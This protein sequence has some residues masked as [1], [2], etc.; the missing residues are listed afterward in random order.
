MK[1]LFIYFTIIVFTLFSCKKQERAP[2]GPTDI[3]IQ[4]LSDFQ[5]NEIT[6]N[7]YD[8][9]FIYGTLNAGATTD[10][11]R[12]NRA[13]SKANISVIINGLKYKTD[14]AIYTYGN[15]LS[16]IKATYQLSIEND[17]LR[18]LRI[19]VIPDSPLK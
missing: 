1:K 14:T 3:R 2:V 7:T 11:H 9:T 6:V 12:F 19:S 10:Y 13:Y 15:Y 16:T 5:M 18:K 8:S 4:N 17:A